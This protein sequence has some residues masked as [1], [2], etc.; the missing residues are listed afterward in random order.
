MKIGQY[1]HRMMY[2]IGLGPLIGRII[3]LLTTTGRK[4]GKRRVT[5]LQYE[6]IDGAFYIGSARG[7]QSDWY[8]NILAN[9]QVEVR[10]KNRRFRG[11]AEPLT[12]PARIADFLEFR[13]QHH[14]RM[15]GAMMKMHHLPPRPTRAQLEELG[16]MLAVVAIREQ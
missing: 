9:P 15:V 13:L 14:P 8:R 5:P 11:L 7:K 1:V 10:V 4:T 3:L 16:V 2:A 12:D 6:E